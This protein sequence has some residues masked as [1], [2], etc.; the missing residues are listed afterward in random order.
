MFGQYFIVAPKTERPGSYSF[1]RLHAS[2]ESAEK[3]A[4]RIC[5]KEKTEAFV[6]QAIRSAKPK[7]VPVEWTDAY[8]E[9][10]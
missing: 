5:I 3:E 6:C 4:A 10:A 9:E 1:T 8:R 7:E 2:K